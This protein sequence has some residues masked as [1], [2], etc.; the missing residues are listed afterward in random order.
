MVFIDEIDAICGPRDALHANPHTVGL[1]TE[2]MV[3]MDGVGHDNE[4]VLV[5]AATNL[6]W[7]LDPAIRRRLQRKIYIP[8][9]DEP[10]RSRMFEIHIGTTPCG[11]DPSHYE[12]LGRRTDG[13]SGSDIGN[14]VQDAL[15]QPVKKVASSKYWRKV[16]KYFLV[17][18]F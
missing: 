18:E 15:M 10:A 9:P 13:L 16:R 4:G 6:P 1:K 5:L 8:L 7:A 11:L 2:I 14:T 17:Q 3:Q 12:E